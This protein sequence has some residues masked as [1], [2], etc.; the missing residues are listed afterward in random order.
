MEK[1]INKS[2]VKLKQVIPYIGIPVIIT[3]LL[4]LYNNVIDEFKLIWYVLIIIF[5]YI[6]AY[7]DFSTKKIPNMLVII[8][9]SAW[10]ITMVP[11]LFYNI[12]DAIY[13]LRDS[14][15]GFAIGGGLFFLIYLISRKGIGGGDVKFMAAAGLFLGLGGTFSAMLYGSILAGLVAV[16][17]LILK[18]IGRKDSIPLVPFLYFGIL[19]TIFYR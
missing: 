8:M 6:A 2:A 10:V 5:G 17:L 7:L 15:L 3:L 4:V 19:I 1:D 13:I 9:L 11:R 16:V 14:A 18:K 12:N